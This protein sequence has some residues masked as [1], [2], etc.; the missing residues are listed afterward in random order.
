MSEAVFVEFCAA[1]ARVR[2]P[3]APRMISFR[4]LEGD[5]TNKRRF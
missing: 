2:D 5:R 4:T 1:A 3:L